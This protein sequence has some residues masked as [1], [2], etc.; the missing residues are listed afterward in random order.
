MLN[1]KLCSE[2]KISIIL[3]KIYYILHPDQIPE[4]VNRIEFAWF[5]GYD[6]K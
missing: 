2:K 5:Y 3:K 1:V 4:G 6:D